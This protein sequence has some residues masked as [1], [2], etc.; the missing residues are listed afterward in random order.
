MTGERRMAKFSKKLLGKHIRTQMVLHRLSIKFYENGIVMK[1][2]G[3][4]GIHNCPQQEHIF[5]SKEN[6]DFLKSF[7]DLFDKSE[8]IV[9]SL[10]DQKEQKDLPHITLEP[11]ESKCTR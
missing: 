11:V 5:I 9:K 7:L 6:T 1:P 4:Q 10:D 2:W 8:K 3:N